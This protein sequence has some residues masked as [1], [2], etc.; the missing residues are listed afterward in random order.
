MIT[1]IR[2]NHR[3]HFLAILTTRVRNSGRQSCEHY[4]FY[5]FKDLLLFYVSFHFFQSI[6]YFIHT[7]PKLKLTCLCEFFGKTTRLK[8]KTHL[9]LINVLTQFYNCR[10]FWSKRDSLLANELNA[11][12]HAR[13]RAL[14]HKSHND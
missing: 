9:P 7:E 11:S 2:T 8:Y 3:V 6:S 1:F 10:N 5:V 14:D 4:N 13:A 12:A